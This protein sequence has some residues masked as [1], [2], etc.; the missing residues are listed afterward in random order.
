MKTKKK[1]W[2]KSKIKEIELNNRIVR[3]ATNEHLGTLEGCIT[4]D[5]IKVYKN[6][7]Y[8]QHISN[9]NLEYLFVLFFY[10]HLHL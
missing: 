7:A 6:L 1:L 10:I 8:K 2:Q 3:S 4:D 5:Y 9:L